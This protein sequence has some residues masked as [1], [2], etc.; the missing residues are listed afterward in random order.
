[1]E[2]PVEARF[3]GLRISS[4]LLPD[5]RRLGEALARGVPDGELDD[6]L[7]S[8]EDY[9]TDADDSG[10]IVRSGGVEIEVN[11]QDAPVNGR[12]RFGEG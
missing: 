4:R 9:A 8:I 3:P 1:M 12:R 5:G 7:G 10:G 2:R 11:A 6:L